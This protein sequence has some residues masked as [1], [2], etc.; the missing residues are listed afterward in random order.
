MKHSPFKLSI[1]SAAL[2]NALV[3]SNTFAE[4]ASPKTEAATEQLE[5]MEHIVVLGEKTEPL[6][7]A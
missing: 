3:V 5:S 4:D 2:L 7:N 1:I 6:E